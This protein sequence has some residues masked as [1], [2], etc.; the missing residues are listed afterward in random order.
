[1]NVRWLDDAVH[2]LAAIRAYIARDNP[3]SAA[4]VSQR[5]REAA[6]MLSK[7]PAA[8]R[9][10][11]IQGTREMVISGTP[12]LLPYRVKDGAVEILRMLHGA[13]RRPEGSAPAVSDEN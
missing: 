1:V 10:G 9:P 2:D 11:R 12:Y 7:F 8:S 6:Q 13:R 3:T 5:I 4:E